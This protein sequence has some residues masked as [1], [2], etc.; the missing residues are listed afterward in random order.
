[1]LRSKLPCDTICSDGQRHHSLTL[2]GVSEDPCCKDLANMVRFSTDYKESIQGLNRAP[3][4]FISAEVC[5]WLSG[6]C[7]FSHVVTAQDSQLDG[8]G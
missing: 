7:C 1:M 5:E 4:N 2:R 6:P 3:G 8:L